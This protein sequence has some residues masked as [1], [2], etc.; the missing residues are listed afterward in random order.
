MNDIF[1]YLASD[2]Y[3]VVNKTLIKTFGLEEA[4]LIGELCSEYKYWLNNDRLED[5]MF[6]SSMENIEENTSLSPYKQRRIIESL[7]EAGIL[8]TRLKGLPAKKY[9]KIDFD[10]LTNALDTRCEKISHLHAKR[11]DT[12]NN[13]ENNNKDNKNIVQKP[14]QTNKDVKDELVKS[15]NKICSNLPKVRVVTQKR[16]K[17]IDKLLKSYDRKEIIK[18]FNIANS[19][20]FLTGQNDRGWKADLDFILREDKFVSIL[21][22]KYG[23]NSSNSKKFSEGSGI[24][25]E[26]YTE[27]EKEYMYEEAVEREKNGQ[28][29]FF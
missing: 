14:T 7:T 25:S 6:Y 3:I 29:G 11:F 2:N 19:T 10:A 26:G 21:E 4:I 16:R 1:N 20:P 15:Y 18:A 23:S 5:D 13:K 24:T 22:G 28:R 12:N 9:F 27:S 17:A 8:E